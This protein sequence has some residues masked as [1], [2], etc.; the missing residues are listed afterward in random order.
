MRWYRASMQIAGPTRCPRIPTAPE[1]C[2]AL[3]VRIRR[4]L[5]AQQSRPATQHVDEPMSGAWRQ[6]G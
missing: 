5:R 3:R 1:A 6:D 4:G 2:R